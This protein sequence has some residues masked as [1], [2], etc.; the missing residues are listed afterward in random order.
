MEEKLGV[1]RRKSAVAS[2]RVRKGSGKFTINGRELKEY[3]PLD[4][5][6]EIILSPLKKF[7]LESA[8]DVV[9]SLKGGGVEAQASALRLGISRAL[10]ADDEARRGELKELGFLTR[11]PRKKERK[12]YGQ[13]G[14]R[15]RFQ[16]SKR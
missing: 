2:V 15:A 3:F 13:R 9:V 4:F 6:R 7:E 10:V 14:A 1:G 16:F 12:K 11:D 8:Y 5:Q